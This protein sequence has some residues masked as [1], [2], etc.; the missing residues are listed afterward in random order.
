MP[1]TCLN[2]VFNE[3]R[4]VKGKN[5]YLWALFFALLELRTA[6]VGINK[7]SSH[8]EELGAEAVSSGAALLTDII[9]NSL[10]DE[11]ASLTAKTLRPDAADIAA[12]LD[13][14][15]MAFGICIRIGLV[16]A[17]IWEVNK[18]AVMYE[19][20]ERPDPIELGVEAE[21]RKAIDDILVKG[22]DLAIAHRGDLKG[23]ACRKCKK[24]KGKSKFAA[25]RDLDCR[26]V[27]DA[28]ARAA[29]HQQ[30][31]QLTQEEYNEIKIA[32]HKTFLC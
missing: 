1:R 30:A 27:V 22:H 4:L 11:A 5:G 32:K 8:M 21:M 31:K 25:W 28:S 29:A 3:E 17:R 16:Q 13:I 9:G 15:K 20:T 14:E 24:F 18:D 10:A 2:G 23:H 19:L 26:K 12:A 7:V 6:D